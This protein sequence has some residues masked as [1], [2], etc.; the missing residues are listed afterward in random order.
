MT[1]ITVFWGYPDGRCRMPSR[2]Q[3]TFWSFAFVCVTPYHTIGN[4]LG[5][6][7]QSWMRQ[8][9][10]CSPSRDYWRSYY[11][12]ERLSS[13]NDS[14]VC[15]CTYQY[16]SKKI[17]TSSG[18]S[19][20]VSFGSTSGT[21]GWTFVSSVGVESYVRSTAASE[22]QRGD[23]SVIMASSTIV[24]K[25]KPSPSEHWTYRGAR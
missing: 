21:D 2:I 3:A 16:D 15:A 25:T 6:F 9:T 23:S 1:T 10:R 24:S 20:T 14:P 22:P 11:E 4:L 12:E 17:R 5:A 18:R 8:F 7:I 13:R 19:A